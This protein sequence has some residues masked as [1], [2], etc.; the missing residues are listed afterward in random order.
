MN[1]TF[2]IDRDG[3][4]VRCLMYA[5]DSG[6]AERVV[7]Y[8][9]GFGGHKGNRAAAR[10]AEHVLS[11]RMGFAVLCFDLPCHGEDV[12]RTLLLE[13]CDRY[14]GCVTDYAAAQ[15][16]GAAPSVYATSFGGYL[17]LK[18][19]SE[20]GWPFDR[21]ALRCPAVPMY[22]VLMNSVMAT[23]DAE[24]LAR[25]KDVLVGFDR[26]I[27]IGPGLLEDLRRADLTK[28]DFTPYRN[29]MLILHGTKDEIVPI[30]AVEAFA[31]KN[32]VPFFPIEN[33]DHRFVD[34][35]KMREAI[36]MIAEFL[37]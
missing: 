33:A 1:R 18:Y 36:G 11:K 7:I 2:H 24:K 31:E 17:T 8:L 4:S 3:C 20:H 28:A 35:G 29:E 12:R 23:E 13:D 19:I 22:D 15:F 26:K 21:V 37:E 34:A 5:P 10:F 6:T 9:H 25:G 32:G 14:L 30:G 27:R 16:P